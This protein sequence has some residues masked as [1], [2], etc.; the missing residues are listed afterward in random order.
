MHQLNK[1]YSDSL[2]KVVSNPLSNSPL[3]SE[4]SFLNL[5]KEL[6]DSYLF[7]NCYV[8]DSPEVSQKQIIEELERYEGLTIPAETAVNKRIVDAYFEEPLSPQDAISIFN[9]LGDIAL[10]SL[11]KCG[12]YSVTIALCMAQHY[13][14]REITDFIMY[15]HKRDD[16]KDVSPFSKNLD[17]AIQL[18]AVADVIDTSIHTKNR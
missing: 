8:W 9:R 6:N 15:S 1:R 2:L 3:Y 18:T 13:E 17:E 16:P 10:N 12:V 11:R 5:A 4:E 14:T 7:K